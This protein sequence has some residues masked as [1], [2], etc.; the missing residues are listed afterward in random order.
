MVQN[1]SFGP[2]EQF[3]RVLRKGSLFSWESFHLFVSNPAQCFSF[4]VANVA[5]FDVTPT[6]HRALEM[7]LSIVR[8]KIEKLVN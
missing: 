3:Q 6:V 7:G 5:S 4:V 2:L 1:G 8:L